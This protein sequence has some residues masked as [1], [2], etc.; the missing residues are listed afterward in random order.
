MGE[1]EKE[2]VI[3]KDFWAYLK[4]NLRE[5]GQ[6]PAWMKGGKTMDPTMIQNCRQFVCSHIVREGSW[7]PCALPKGHEGDQHY[8]GG[9]CFTHGPYVNERPGCPPACPKCD[10]TIRIFTTDEEPFYGNNRFKGWPIMGAPYDPTAVQPIPNAPDT[11]QDVGRFIIEKLAEWDHV[12]L[13]S[14]LPEITSDHEKRIEFGEKKYGQRLRTNNGRDALL[15]CYQEV[16]DSISYSAQYYLEG[17]DLTLMYDCVML[18]GK[19][20]ERLKEKHD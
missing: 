7:F 6:W 15:D 2:K 20:K 12:Q 8:A 17:G 5:V 10:N 9:T 18:S 16:L 1:K 4:S 13:L 11:E 19:I 3:G 14:H